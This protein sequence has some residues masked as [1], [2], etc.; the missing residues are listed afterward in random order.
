[1]S[2]RWK[3]NLMLFA[4]TLVLT[5]FDSRIKIWVFGAHMEPQVKFDKNL[6]VAR[7]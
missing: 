6:Q 5:H 1:M 3:G 7:V 2:S 4:M